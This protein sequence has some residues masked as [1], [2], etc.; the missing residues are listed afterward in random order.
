MF[1]T[2]D[3]RG[4]REKCLVQLHLLKPL[5]RL[6]P[7]PAAMLDGG[8]QLMMLV[9]C[10]NFVIVDIITNSLKARTVNTTACCVTKQKD[11]VCEMENGCTSRQ[12]I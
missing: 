12:K 10:T 2:F 11:L 6:S 9:P 5:A 8:G 3:R 1:H 7:I 4:R